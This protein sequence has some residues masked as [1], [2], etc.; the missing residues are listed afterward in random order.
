M[1]SRYAA[2]QFG[3]SIG[4]LSWFCIGVRRA[5]SVV[6]NHRELIRWNRPEKSSFRHSDNVGI[7]AVREP[8]FADSTP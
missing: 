3:G 8:H 4:R 1:A 6:R 5:V 7:H 2:N